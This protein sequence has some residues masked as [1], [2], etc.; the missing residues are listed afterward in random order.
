MISTT[1]SFFTAIGDKTVIKA[2]SVRI[3]SYT[4]IRHP[5]SIGRRR[6]AGIIIT[7]P[8]SQNNKLGDY[9]GGV[10]KHVSNN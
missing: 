8:L 3:V 1:D 7:V 2:P 9:T 10:T 6:R 4:Q 5:R